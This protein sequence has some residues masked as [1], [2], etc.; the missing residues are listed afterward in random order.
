MD[1]ATRKYNLIQE[2]T[3]IDERLLGK[4]EEFLKA[5]KTDWFDELSEE[6]QS[7]IELGVKQAENKEIVPHD[8][9]M[10]KFKKWH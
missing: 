5:N 1:L 10:D 2:L 8:K 3:T 9:V 7:E 6:E 4:L